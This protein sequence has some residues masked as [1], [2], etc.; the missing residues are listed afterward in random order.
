[1]PFTQLGAFGGINIYKSSCT[2]GVDMDRKEAQQL[3]YSV[4]SDLHSREEF[5]RDPN[6]FAEANGIVFSAE[7]RLRADEVRGLSDS[8]LMERIGK[9]CM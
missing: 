7:D 5:L 1:M 2:G 8:Q 4:V 6:A 3:A 9:L